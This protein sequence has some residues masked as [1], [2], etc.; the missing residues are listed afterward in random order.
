MSNKNAHFSTSHQHTPLPLKGHLTY[1]LVSG[2][3]KIWPLYT[4]AGLNL[5]VLGEVESNSIGNS[6]G[7]DLPAIQEIPV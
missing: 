3:A 6:V 7:K 1:Q 4:G 2:I 5:R